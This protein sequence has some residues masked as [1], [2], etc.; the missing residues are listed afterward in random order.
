LATIGLDIRARER[1]RAWPND[2]PGLEQE[3]GAGVWLKARPGLIDDI[4][5]PK[6]KSPGADRLRTVPDALWLSFGGHERDPFVD[7]FVIE[8]CGSYSNLMDKRSR[9]AP[10]MHS[11]LTTCPLPWLL[12]ARSRED[13]LARW[14]CIR[15]IANEPTQ[16]MILPV[17]DI[18]VMYALPA[19]MYDAFTS[20][21]V[22]H[23][24]EFF[25]PANALLTPDGWQDPTIR[26]LI[27]R[28]SIRANFWAYNIAAE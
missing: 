13:S 10:S 15:V 12:G 1:L 2:P 17:R 21:Q 6:L 14:K 25:V 9:F 7:I 18:R 3:M 27:A 26:A 8:V 16:A 11:M 4:D 20:S 5:V 23:A 24:H 22:P 28:T 19:K